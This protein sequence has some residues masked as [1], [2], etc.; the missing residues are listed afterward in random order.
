[1]DPMTGLSNE[2]FWTSGTDFGST[3]G[4][5]YW[6]GNGQPITFNDWGPDEPNNTLY[7]NGEYEHCLELWNP[8]GNGYIWNDVICSQEAYFICEK[9]EK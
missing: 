8:D 4:H 6:M 9:S 2:R 1:M 5:Y 7:T 3:L